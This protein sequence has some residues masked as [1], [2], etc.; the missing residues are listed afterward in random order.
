[1]ADKKRRY[2]YQG[3]LSI[4]IENF[5]EFRKQ[6]GYAYTSSE[7]AFKAFDTFCVK[8]ENQGL[9]PQQLA[10]AWVK[11]ENGRPKYDGGC[12]VRQLGQYLSELGHPQAFT[13]LCTGGRPPIAVGVNPGPFAMEIN[14]FVNYKKSGGRKYEAGESGIKSFGKF[15]AMKKNEFLS[16]QQLADAWMAKAK[17][18][19]GGSY[20]DV[21]RGFGSYLAMR[22][23]DKQFVVPYA[24]G[25]TPR[26]AFAGY[27]SVFADG[28]E[29][30]L[31]TKRDSGLKYR[32]EEF[33]L[34]DFDRF[35]TGHPGLPAQRL[36]EEYI[37]NK[38]ACGNDKYRRSESVIKALGDYLAENSFFNSFKIA[39]ETRVAGPY[40]A[41]VSAFVN[42][43]RACGF[44]YCSSRYW[45][46]CFD[47]FCAEKENGFLS[48]QQMADKWMLKRDGEHPNTR[49]GR[50][51]PV[52]VFGK[53]L[54]NIGHPKAFEIADDATRMI[55]PK[56]PYLF[57]EDEINAFFSACAELEPV[58][59]DPSMHIVLPA[60]F[61]F[62]HCMGVRTCELDI[63]MENVNFDTGE[64]VIAN[65]KTGDRAVYM[66]GELSG[67]II[68]YNHAIEK[69]FPCR[70]HLFPA[71]VD[72]PRKDFAKRFSEIW[73]SSVPANERGAPR[74]YDV[75]HHFLYRNVEL[76]MSN[77]GDANA[78][79]PYIMRH[80]GHKLPSS[81]Q[82][83]F[84]LSPPIRKEVSRIKSSLDWMIPD[85]P[86]VPY[87]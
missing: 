67:F 58:D 7:A 15:C 50:V 3:P 60:A 83:Y 17:E 38:N 68:E 44:K 43:K 56:P 31:K 27:A 11:P 73:A 72:R 6:S 81:F 48:P 35:C 63:L 21:V 25:E 13:I 9:T 79:Q 41:E 61:L 87:E 4:E 53:Y 49:A 23:S 75:R 77:G 33:V 42:F 52:R 85:V 5:I 46:R 18:K 1:M 10:E 57:S 37:I 14:E 71:S 2:H 36:A 86:E 55:A 62:M 64:V 74:L 69:V 65:A 22:G 84:H 45:L 20:I 47:K 76:C 28:I 8:I 51:G 30:F 29:S 24:N 40:A 12:C 32:G 39:G 78:M 59:K 34:K 54:A 82:Y 26:L 80:M 16:P 19:G 70:R 66:S